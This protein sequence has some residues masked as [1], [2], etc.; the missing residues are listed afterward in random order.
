MYLTYLTHFTMIICRFLLTGGGRR[1]PF[2]EDIF[3]DYCFL[4]RKQLLRNIQRKSEKT[5]KTLHLNEQKVWYVRCTKTTLKDS[6]NQHA[7]IKKRHND[8]RNCNITGSQILSSVSAITT[9]NNPKELHIMEALIIHQHKPLINTQSV[10]S[11]SALN[12]F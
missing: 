6:L 12:I 3:K 8:H 2:I 9:V 11:I 7:G 4:G 1:Y 5:L 10:N